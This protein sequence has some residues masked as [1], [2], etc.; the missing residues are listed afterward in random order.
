MDGRGAKVLPRHQRSALGGTRQDEEVHDRMET[1]HGLRSCPHE[2]IAILGQQFQ[3]RGRCVSL[4]R[5]QC[6]RCDRDN[7]DGQGIVLI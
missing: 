3:L 4:D 7:S 1:I 5:P 6:G 2:I